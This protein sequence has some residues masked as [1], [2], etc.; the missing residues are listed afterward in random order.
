M[1]KQLALLLWLAALL[2]PYRGLSQNEDTEAFINGAKSKYRT[3]GHPKAKSLKISIEYPSHWNREEGERP[4]I[5]QKFVGR[6]SGGLVPICVLQI[7]DLPVETKSFSEQ[8]IADIMFS[9]DGLKN[10]VPDDMLFLKG[11]ATK[12]DAQP[13]AWRIGS[14]IGTRAGLEFEGYTLQQ[15]LIY[16]GKLVVLECSVGGLS[17]AGNAPG[18][19]F[20]QY[21]PLFQLMGNSI[22]I[23]DKW[24]KAI[25]DEDQTAI[26]NATDDTGENVF[27]VYAISFLLTWGIGLTPPVLIRFVIAKRPIAKSW[28][29]AVVIFFGIVNMVVF[30]ILGGTSKTVVIVLAYVS[31]LILRTSF[32]KQNDAKKQ[33]EGKT[34]IPKQVHGQTDVSDLEAYR[35]IDDSSINEKDKARVY[36]AVLGL[37][38]TVKK[39][40]IIDAYKK[41]IAQY[42]PDK[43]SHLGAEFQK[44]AE[45]KTKDINKAFYYLKRKFN[46]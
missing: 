26:F 11:E 23:H 27:W 43:V 4:H 8:E 30:R 37:H 42:H 14:L 19:L 31:F 24:E 28:A 38:G 25:E 15:M 45:K 16:S 22:I 35:E 9:P 44:Y 34:T 36:G 2:F 7:R 1:V 10:T 18:A 40:D 13:G 46:L 3:D 21:L 39:H 32:K 29:Y 20:S 12:Y 33:V 6:S 17:K 41:L 5:V